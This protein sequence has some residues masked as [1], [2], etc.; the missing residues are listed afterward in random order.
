MIQISGR[1]ALDMAL[2]KCGGLDWY[3]STLLK[4]ELADEVDQRNRKG[5]LFD[6]P[7]FDVTAA[8]ARIDGDVELYLGFLEMFRDGNAEEIAGLFSAIA[9]G[10]AA[11]ARRR[12]HSIKGSAGTVGAV[13]LQ[14]A[15]A[16]LEGSLK[17]PEF[18]R[19]LAAR[20]EVEWQQVLASLSAL[21]GVPG[22]PN[23]AVAHD[24]EK[25]VE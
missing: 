22:E 12:A 2:H 10:D 17:E 20:V 19:D 4:N 8:L 9:R 7:G 16:E 11:E 1:D 5:L 24:R 18:A 23:E 3:M 21:L 25:K 14:I 15:A 6:V 13:Q